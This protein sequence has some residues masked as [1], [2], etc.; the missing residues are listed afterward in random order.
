MNEEGS[1]QHRKR[2][3][4]KKGIM[5]ANSNEDSNSAAIPSKSL[6]SN[7]VKAV[8]EKNHKLFLKTSVILERKPEI[9]DLLKKDNKEEKENLS[10]DSEEYQELYPC[11]YC[12]KVFLQSS[13][14]QWHYQ[15]NHESN[16]K[17]KK[18]MLM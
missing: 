14:R 4:T 16:E 7:V 13:Y 6:V 1:N 12:Q 8:M 15:K 17:R 9:E 10:G 5:K 3:K 18:Y 2:K 11:K